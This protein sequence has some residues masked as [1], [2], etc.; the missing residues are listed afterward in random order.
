M[1]YFKLGIVIPIYAGV[2]RLWEVER[3]TKFTPG[4]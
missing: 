3:M 4:M 1:G 2:K